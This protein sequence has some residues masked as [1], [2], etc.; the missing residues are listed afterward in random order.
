MKNIEYEE[1]IE[2]LAEVINEKIKE[3]EVKR[4]REFGRYSLSDKINPGRNKY[5]RATT[6]EIYIIVLYMV[7]PKLRSHIEENVPLELFA[8]KFNKRVLSV[9]YSNN[10]LLKSLGEFTQ[11]E[12]A[13]IGNYF[14]MVH[15]CARTKACVNEWVKVLKAT[16]E[17]RE[18]DINL[19]SDEEMLAH[20]EEISKLK[21]TTT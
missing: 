14:T 2:A 10:N 7:E 21:T 1:F 12:L 15:E 9:L 11:V 4:L 5:P 19:L 3:L 17:K 6:A 18:T 13:Y 20:F 8:T 16:K